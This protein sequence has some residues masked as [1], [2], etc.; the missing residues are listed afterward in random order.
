MEP[1]ARS[2]WNRCEGRWPAHTV[3]RPWSVGEGTA[4]SQE[5]SSATFLLRWPAEIPG[6]VVHI[7]HYTYIYCAWPSVASEP[8]WTVEAL[9]LCCVRL[10][11]HIGG[12]VSLSWPGRPYNKVVAFMLLLMACAADSAAQCTRG[13]T[14]PPSGPG[15]LRVSGPR[16]SCADTRP[17]PSTL[18]RAASRAHRGRH[19]A[20]RGG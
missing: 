2:P 12:P 5:P 7:T 19:R 1:R 10:Y 9:G 14:V 17:M 20:P 4:S 8:S 3:G 11:T 15:A 18:C 6:V 13:P 16:P